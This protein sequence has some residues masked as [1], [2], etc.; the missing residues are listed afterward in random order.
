MENLHAP[1]VPSGPTS[2]RGHTNGLK[3]DGLTIDELQ[4]KKDSMEAELRALGGVLDSVRNVFLLK[5]L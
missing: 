4:A 5:Q 2:G 3:T 1:T